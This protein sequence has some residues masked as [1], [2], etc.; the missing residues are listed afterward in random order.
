MQLRVERSPSPLRYA[1]RL[2]DPDN[3]NVLLVAYKCWG[4]DAAQVQR[5]DGCVA[6]PFPNIVW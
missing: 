2:G 1:P 6:V 5:R 4:W 3:G